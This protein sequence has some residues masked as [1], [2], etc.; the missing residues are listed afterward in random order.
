[1]KA[2]L[3]AQKLGYE[4][5]LNAQI[6]IASKEAFKRK[7]KSLLSQILDLDE[8]QIK[9]L[10][11][12]IDEFNSESLENLQSLEKFI[13]KNFSLCENC[14]LHDPNSEFT[15]FFDKY[16]QGKIE[17]IGDYYPNEHN[18][19]ECNQYFYENYKE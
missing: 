9:H 11:T 5:A 1:M 14:N 18:C 13:N 6:I 12:H 16:A 8:R 15:S 2:V 3:N 10:L 7:L 19:S 17:N 4:I